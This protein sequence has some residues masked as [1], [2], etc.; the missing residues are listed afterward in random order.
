MSTTKKGALEDTQRFQIKESEEKS[1]KVDKRK[2]KVFFKGEWIDIDKNI[3]ALYEIL[4]IKREEKTNLKNSFLQ[5]FK[6]S[7]VDDSEARK[8]A[9]KIGKLST[10]INELEKL[11]SK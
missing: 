11:L 7:T 2:G 10:D 5:D 4:E 6:E 1:F 9:K 8:I 3:D